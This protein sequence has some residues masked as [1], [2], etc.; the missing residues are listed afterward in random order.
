MKKKTKVL[1]AE[2]LARQR[3]KYKNQ[4][5]TKAKNAEQAR[6]MGRVTAGKII[7]EHN[8]VNWFEEN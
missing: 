5:G 7:F 1:A 8:L 2:S 6:Q 3:N 4:K